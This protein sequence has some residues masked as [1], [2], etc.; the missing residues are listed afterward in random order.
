MI[1][2]RSKMFTGGILNTTAP[3]FIRGRKYDQDMDRLG[4]METSQRELQKPGQIGKEMRR[5]GKVLNEA[6]KG[7]W[8]RTELKE[9]N[10]D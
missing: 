2:L 1:L 5:L 10:T 8:L 3:G 6:R 9:N 4:R 7:Q